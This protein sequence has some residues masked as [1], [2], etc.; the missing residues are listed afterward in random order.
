MKSTILLLSLLV[1][2]G[3]Q[4]KTNLETLTE[5]S[6]KLQSLEKIQYDFSLVKKDYNSPGSSYSHSGTLAID[7]TK[8]N[9][10]G[11]NIYSKRI[12]EGEKVF[13]RLAIQDTLIKR[14]DKT[15]TIVKS[16]N[17]SVLTLKSNLDLYFNIFDIRKSLPIALQDSTLTVLNITD[18]ILS[19]TP[20]LSVNFK[21]KKHIMGGKLYDT[22]G[23]DNLYQ[24][25][26]RKKDYVPLLWKLKNDDMTMTFSC[27]NIQLNIDDALWKYNPQ[28]EYTSIT[29]KEYR[30]R[31]KNALNKKLGKSFP[32]WQLSSIRGEKLSNTYFKNKVTL[33][34]FFFVGCVGSINSKPFI[35]DL[36]KKYGKKLNILNVEIQN[37]SQKEVLS[38]VEKHKLK[39]PVLYG[40]KELAGQLGVLGCPTYVLVNK[41]GEIIFS[42]LGDKTGLIDLIEKQL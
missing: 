19:K 3:C 40:G 10:L 18:T 4:K 12:K 27:T 17:S 39:E 32:N 16:P 41:S 37:Y 28:K 22:K 25:V 26:V 13:E 7:F 31:Q 11:A 21:I 36:H 38:F 1:I 29:G 9:T 8:E 35:N 14:I 15:K 42:S 20:S 34:E 24:I 33:Y 23:S 30:L 2:I 6:N 5:I